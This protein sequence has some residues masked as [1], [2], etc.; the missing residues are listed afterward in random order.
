M[1]LTSL[2]IKTLRDERGSILSYGC[3]L[4]LF[5][6]WCVT[7][8]PSISRFPE[9]DALVQ[10][11]PALAKAFIGE[12]PNLT[13][14]EGFL[15]VEF[16]NL[17]LPLLGAVFVIIEGTSFIAGEEDRGTLDLLLSN[18]I[19]RWRT[20][21]EKFAALVVAVALIALLIIVGFVIS[22]AIVRVNIGYDRVLAATVGAIPLILT[23]AGYSLLG[24]CLLPSRKSAALMATGL[25]VVF[26][27]LNSLAVLVEFLERFRWASIFYYYN[28][29][30]ILTVGLNWAHLGLLLGLT[31]LL[32]LVS[33]W[34][35]D[36]RDIAI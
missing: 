35:F 28:G 34:A 27:F 4:A 10:S 23:I 5:A 9:L 36:R 8:F 15:S 33:V 21:L 25:T 3:G 20:V 29:Y 2:F 31:T 12:L 11:Y 30:S 24:S 7:L 19:P 16:F 17:L 13:S 18:P 1:K 14:I 26:Y 6:A 32:V 22:L